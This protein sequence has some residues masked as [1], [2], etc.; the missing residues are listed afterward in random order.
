MSS[1]TSASSSRSRVT[2]ARPAPGS[3]GPELRAATSPPALRC[4]RAGRARSGSRRRRRR[5]ARRPAAPSV[6]SGVPHITASWRTGG[7]SQ[8]TTSS[9]SSR[10]GM[11]SPRRRLLARYALAIVRALRG[12][13]RDGRCL[14]CA[15]T[16][17][18]PA[19]R[20]T[21]D[22]VRHGWR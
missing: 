1:R 14:R 13:L 4:P 22:A 6:T 10:A 12:E 15:A 7:S 17:A 19:A 18:L 21:V 5:T 3:P 9:A 20:F 11:S 2:T 16:P 8:P